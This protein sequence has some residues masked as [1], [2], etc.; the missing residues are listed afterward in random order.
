MH[1]APRAPDAALF[2]QMSERMS[3]CCAKLENRVERRKIDV[4]EKPTSTAERLGFGR[5]L[6]LAIH[7]SLVMLRQRTHQVLPE[8]C[9][10]PH[11]RS[12]DRNCTI[13]A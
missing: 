8:L 6:W 4:K 9:Y 13:P 12:K 11:I 10:F 5:R 1:L 3:A 7:A 2:T